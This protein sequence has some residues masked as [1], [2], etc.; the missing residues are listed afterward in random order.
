M[1]EPLLLDQPVGPSPLPEQ[2]VD[3]RPILVEPAVAVHV[4]T[5]Q[6]SQTSQ[7]R[8]FYRSLIRLKIPS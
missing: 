3:P 5:P 4:A 6:A 7:I 1:Q 8:S 2:A